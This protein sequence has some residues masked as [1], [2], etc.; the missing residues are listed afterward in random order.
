MPLFDMDAYTKLTAAER[1]ELNAWL[2]A[3]QLLNLGIVAC[4]PLGH[5]LARV[6]Y[7]KKRDGKPYLDRNRNFVTATKTLSTATRCPLSSRKESE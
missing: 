2:E 1:S 7:L 6:T 3:E 4:E 5:R